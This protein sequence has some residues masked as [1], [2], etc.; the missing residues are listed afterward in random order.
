M[1]CEKSD[2]FIFIKGIRESPTFPNL[3]WWC[4]ITSSWHLA[5]RHDEIVDDDKKVIY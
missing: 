3:L 2:D 5:Y 4:K 1:I